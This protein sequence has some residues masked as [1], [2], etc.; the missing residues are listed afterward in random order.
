MQEQLSALI[1]NL[2]LATD[3]DENPLLPTTAML[4]P[5]ESARIFANTC[6]R[7]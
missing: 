1:L 4:G 3:T 2:K 5:H 7:R 6:I